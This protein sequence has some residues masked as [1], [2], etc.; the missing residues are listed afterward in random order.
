MH[1]T[2][3]EKVDSTT[4]KQGDILDKTEALTSLIK[5]IHPHYANGDYTHFQILTQSCDLVR[6]GSDSKCASR[7]LTLAAIRGLSTVV[8]RIIE[9][10]VDDNK[11]IEIENIKWCSN[12]HKDRISQVIGSLFNNNDKNHFF[13]KAFPENGLPEDSCTFLHLSIAIRAYEHYDLCLEAKRIELS[14]NFQSKL[15]WLVGNLYSRVGTE[16]FVPACFDTPA[17]FRDH[18]EETLNKYVA[19][20]DSSQFSEF[21]RCHL[22]D[23]TLTGEQL[24]AAAESKIQTKRYSQLE[25]LVNLIEKAAQIEP[26]QKEKLKNFLDSSA[27]RR[28]LKI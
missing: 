25:T 16:D 10:E 20:V 28:F 22:D 17:K 13:L 11:Q 8:E 19:W 26:K 1:F 18:I 21:R 24:I 2:Y 4:L 12:K 15:G 5:K 23:S 7:Y 6:R 3:A 9:Q 27:A 14:S